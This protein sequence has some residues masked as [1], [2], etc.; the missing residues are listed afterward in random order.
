MHSVNLRLIRAGYIMWFMSDRNIYMDA[1]RIGR[2]N[3]GLS[4][5]TYFKFK[6]D[7]IVYSF[8]SVEATCA[9]V[10]QLS[11]RPFLVT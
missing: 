5:H 6:N 3:D 10:H 4:W 2:D 1:F 9:A 7:Q 8:I 11:L